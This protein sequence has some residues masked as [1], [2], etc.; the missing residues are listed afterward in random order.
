MAGR[1]DLAA[2]LLHDLLHDHEVHK[3]NREGVFQWYDVSRLGADM[4]QALQLRLPLLHLS[5]G[6]LRLGDVALQAFGRELPPPPAG[7]V[8]ARYDFRSRH[9]GRFGGRD[10]YV[11]SAEESLRALRAFVAAERARSS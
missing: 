2:V 11:V 1:V 10:G 6:P 3:L 4:D 8:A 7:T 9:A 5:V